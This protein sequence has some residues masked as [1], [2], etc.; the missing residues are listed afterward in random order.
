MAWKETLK[1]RDILNN[2]STFKHF[3]NGP[4]VQLYDDLSFRGFDIIKWS[5]NAML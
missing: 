3:L 4:R 2:R 1:I 5:I